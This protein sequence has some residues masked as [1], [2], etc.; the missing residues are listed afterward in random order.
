MPALPSWVR[1]LV[2]AGVVALLILCLVSAVLWPQLLFS[3]VEGLLRATRDLG[4]IGW[5]LFTLAQV[6]VALSGVL[7]ASLICML[8]G[9]TYGFGLGFVLATLGTMG[10]AMLA[11]ALSRSLFRTSIE[12]MLS[13]HERLA[14]FDQIIAQD[15]WKIVCL[16]RI[17][18]LMPFSATSFA[19]GL[20]SIRFRNYLVGTLASLPALLGYV[21]IGTVADATLVAWSSGTHPFKWGL[22]AAGGVATLVLTLYVGKIAMRLGMLPGIKVGAGLD[23]ET[24]AG[25]PEARAI[26]VKP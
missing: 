6:V 19:L 25:R 26:E 11:F 14:S 13:R 22:L 3:H 1:N 5:V 21:F 24:E 16:L 20:S 8:A 18:P 15:G 2:L 9:A 12:R 4:A 23:Q 7:P 17:S 10:G